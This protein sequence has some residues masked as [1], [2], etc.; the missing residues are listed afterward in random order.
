MNSL[1]RN[2]FI[3]FLTGICFQTVFGQSVSF[4]NL[5]REI[6]DYNREENYDKSI[7]R[8][9]SIIQNPDSSP[10]DRYYAYLEKAIT[11]KRVFDYQSALENLDLAYSE[12]MKTDQKKTVEARVT[13]EKLFVYFDTQNSKTDE[14]LEKAKSVDFSLL[15]NT[16]KAFYNNVLAMKAMDKKEFGLARE[17]LE[18]GLRL[19]EKDDPQNLGG[20]YG[21]F[22][23]LADRTNDEQLALV[24]YEKGLESAQKYKMKV[25]S[26]NLNLQLGSFYFNRGDYQK[27]YKYE[28]QGTD[29]YFSYNILP[30]IEK[31][32]GVDEVIAQNQAEMEK[33]Y[34]H[35][36]N[37]FLTVTTLGLLLLLLV[38]FQLYRV[39][40]RRKKLVEAD[41]KRIRKELDEI[42]QNLKTG[43]QNNIELEKYNLTDR[44]LEIIELIKQGKS[45]KEIGEKLFISENT[46]KYHLK[47][48]YNILGIESRVYLK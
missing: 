34:A 12:G 43:N 30:K 41:N 15:D 33:K 23:V 22:M 1:K 24:S 27:A 6:S 16:T 46:V 37:L 11:F 44:Q 32:K 26:I 39:N 14:Y 35:T 9:S 19:V 18:E 28:H 31:M 40:N 29:Y 21:M 7:A 42:T 36:K 48:I 38:L 4:Q 17:K 25:Y 8:L 13:I 3:L 45:N 20:I 2:I 47:I 10:I 5:N